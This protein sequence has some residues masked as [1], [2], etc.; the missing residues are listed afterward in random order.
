M[1]VYFRIMHGLRGCYMPD[2]NEPYAISTRRE[3]ANI[4]RDNLA[5]HDAPKSR[6]NDVGIRKLWGKIVHARSASMVSFLIPTTP[7][8]GLE[9]C[10]MTADEYEAETAND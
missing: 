2:T 9:M 7:G 1:T 6:F 5:Y 10:G 4:L 3:L 8:Y